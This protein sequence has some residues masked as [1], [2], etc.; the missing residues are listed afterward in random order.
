MGRMGRARPHFFGRQGGWGPPKKMGSGP[1]HPAHMGLGRINIGNIYCRK[2]GLSDDTKFFCRT[3]YAQSTRKKSGVWLLHENWHPSLFTLKFPVD[4]CSKC[5]KWHQPFI[6][7]CIQLH[8][9]SASTHFKRSSDSDH[10]DAFPY[11]QR[12]QAWDPYSH[13]TICYFLLLSVCHY[14]VLSAIIII[15]HYLLLSVSIC[16][17]LLY[18]LLS[19]GL[20]LW[21]AACYDA[22]LPSAISYP[23]LSAI[24]SYHPRSLYGICHSLCFLYA[25]TICQ[26]TSPDVIFYYLLSPAMI[27]YYPRCLRLSG[28]IS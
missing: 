16:Q 10:I 18:N 4:C 17:Y 23:S 28:V 25:T 6:C 20:L 24:I 2:R 13:M 3:P 5:L 9:S 26:W 14:L 12:G 11:Q 15:C 27:C 1:A 22:L 8:P 19:F 21:A 7:F